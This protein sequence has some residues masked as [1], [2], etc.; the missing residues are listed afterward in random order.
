M[1]NMWLF[2]C[3]VK[4]KMPA[5]MHVC[6]HVCVCVCLCVHACL[7]VCVCVYACIRVARDGAQGLIL[8]VCSTPKPHP[9]LG[10]FDSIKV[11]RISFQIVFTETVRLTNMKHRAMLLD[12]WRS[13]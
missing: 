2:G 3:D 7:C 9:S 8:G 12:R 6:V 1:D 10:T 5:C 4:I 13:V 11:K